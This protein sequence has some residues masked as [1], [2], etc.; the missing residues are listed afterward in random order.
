MNPREIWGFFYLYI[1]YRLKD[2]ANLKE[3]FVY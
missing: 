3:V 2:L 1:D